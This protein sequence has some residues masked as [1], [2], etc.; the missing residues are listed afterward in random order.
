MAPGCHP[1]RWLGVM[2][3]ALLESQQPRKK[4]PP[5]DVTH[6]VEYYDSSGN[7]QQSTSASGRLETIEEAAYT[8]AEF[9]GAKAFQVHRIRDGAAVSDRKEVP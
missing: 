2:D 4:R 5:P 8:F 9:I 1:S 3:V 7:I 6:R